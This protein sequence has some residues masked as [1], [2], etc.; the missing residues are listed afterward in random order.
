VRFK[1]LALFL[2]FFVILLGLTFFSLTALAKEKVVLAITGEDVTDV[3]NRFNRSQLDYQIIIQSHKFR[4]WRYA[5]NQFRF[6]QKNI[7]KEQPNK[8]VDI[9]FIDNN[10]LAG[11]IQSRWLENISGKI[12]KLDDIVEGLAEAASENDAIYA[13]P[14]SNKGLVLYYRK[15]LHE[16]YRLPLPRTLKEL[17]KNALILMEKESLDHG[18]T[19]HYSAMHLDILPL[20]WSNGGN[21]V[22]DGEVVLNSPENIETLSYLQALAHQKILPGPNTFEY[23]KGAYSNAKKLFMQGKSAYIITWNNRI[24]DFDNSQITGKFGILPIP[25]L[26][27]GQKSFSVIGSWYFAI[28]IFSQKKEG[29]IRF[30]NY[31]FSDKT[32]KRMALNSTS[33]LSAIKSVYKIPEL[34]LKNPYLSSLKRAMGNMRHRLRDTEEPKISFILENTIK[35]ILIKGKPVRELLE[36]SHKRIGL[37][38]KRPHK[39]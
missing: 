30:L 19:V 7:E 17:E 22:S 23:L 34:R 27:V 13:L 35:E 38:Y 2:M 26:K 21:I 24:S 12:A 31:F 16:K 1:V 14:F 9:V 37:I 18:L 29:A 8:V 36:I 3:V 25:S 28:N 5:L 11:M 15:D 39:N 4:N 10:W 32:Q 6:S 20:M 33:F